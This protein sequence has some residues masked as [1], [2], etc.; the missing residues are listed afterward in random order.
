MNR[1]L[2]AGRPSLTAELWHG[3]QELIAELRQ[4]AQHLAGLVRHPVVHTSGASGVLNPNTVS[5]VRVWDSGVDTDALLAELAR[6]PVT[7]DLLVLA[8]IDVD[9]PALLASGWYWHEDVI[10]V[11]H[12]RPASFHGT[13][14]DG[15]ALRPIGRS[16]LSAIRSLLDDCFGPDELDEHLPDDVL[17]V[18]GLHL[19]AAVDDNGGLAATVGIRPTRTGALLFS[20]AT[21]QPHRRQG[22][23]H[24][25]VAQAARLSARQGASHVRA[26]V[27]AGVLPFYQRLGFYP[28]SRWRR[29]EPVHVATSSAPSA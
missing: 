4:D 21:A 2:P 12:D 8:D 11:R 6:L 1:D 28:Y 9:D 15:Y 7:P 23:A 10:T 14:P 22:L 17:E 24:C 3:H 13:V 18:P 29:Y 20:L 5:V 25:L 26:D 27:T 19:L 16:Q